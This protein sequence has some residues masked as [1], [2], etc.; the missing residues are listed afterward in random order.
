[1][2][3]MR[4]IYLIN[5]PLNY[6]NRRTDKYGGSLE[7]RYCFAVEIVQAIKKNVVKIPCLVAI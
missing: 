5:L 6:V 3:S 4:V 2:L 1:M 7:N